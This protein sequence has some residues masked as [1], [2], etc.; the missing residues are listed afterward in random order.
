[1]YL[2]PVPKSKASSGGL[3]SIKD[4]RSGPILADATPIDHDLAYIRSLGPGPKPWER[5]Q[6]TAV[7]AVIRAIHPGS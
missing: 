5:P 6:E 7:V 2:Y 4:T 3:V 1:M